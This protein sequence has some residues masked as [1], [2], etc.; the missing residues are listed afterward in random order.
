M[1]KTV[2]EKILECALALDV[3]KGTF[4][5]EDLV[6]RCW[7]R[8]PDTFGLQGYADRYP[9]SNRILKKIMG[10]EGLRGKGWLRKVGE[11][12]YRVTEVAR[13]TVKARETPSQKETH[14]RASTISRE[15]IEI[16]ERIFNSRAIQKFRV[17]LPITFGD[18][19]SFWNI[20]PRSNAYHLN[21]AI[22][23]TETALAS[24]EEAL[25][26]HANGGLVLPGNSTSI[27]RSDLVVARSLQSFLKQN[28]TR[29]LEVI[30]ERSDERIPR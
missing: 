5:A 7:E 29:E 11:K 10:G 17:R 15:T 26:A 3:E 22:R 9:D 4:N 13:Q 19:S 24:V 27:T 18:L 16:L 6:V 23:E 25:N 21:I 14:R 30:R 12:K 20:S 1:S 8:F 28:F 2:D